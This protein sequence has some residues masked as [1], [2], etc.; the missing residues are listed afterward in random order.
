MRNY[1]KQLEKSNQLLFV[2]REVDPKYE[3]AA[4]TKKVQLQGDQAI[5]FNRVKRTDFPVIT[6]LYGSRRRLCDLIDAPI[7]RKDEFI[8]KSVPGVDDTNLQDYIKSE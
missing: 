1:I 2:D 5:H 7:D 4:V 3:L 8:R 6:N